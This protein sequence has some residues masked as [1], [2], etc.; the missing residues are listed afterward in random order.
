[1]IRKALAIGGLLAFCL[2]ATPALAKRK[3]DPPPFPPA[4]TLPTP[5]PNQPTFPGLPGQPI[6]S[7]PSLPP[8]GKGNPK[9]GP[10]VPF[11]LATTLPFP[12]GNIEGI[13]KIVTN[14]GT[15]ISFSFTV[16]TDLDGHQYLSVAQIDTSTGQLVAEGVGISVE[17]DKLVRAAMKAKNGAAY[18]LFIGSYKNTN[19][20]VVGGQASKSVTV[21]TVRPFTDLTGDKDVQVIVQKV[22]DAPL[23]SARWLRS[24]EF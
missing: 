12:W 13:W 3:K 10:E 16:Q 23:A 11:P 17:T 19:Q 6:P 4:P 24:N 14:E 1:M 8:P 7:L 18:M 21:L 15:Q 2:N 9:G 20:Y 5:G 22:S